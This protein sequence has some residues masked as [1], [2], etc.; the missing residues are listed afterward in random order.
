MDKQKIYSDFIKPI[1]I[2]TV[3]CVVTSALL[4][5]T[6][7]VTAPIILKA[8]IDSANAQRATL[9]PADSF[10]EIESTT[11]GVSQIYEADD[12]TGYVITSAAN[13]YNGSVPVM[14]AFDTNG[15]I[16]G[17]SFLPNSETPGFGQK[18]RE[19]DF[20]GQFAGMDAQPITLSDIDAVSGATVSSSAAVQ[21]I[22]YAIQGYAQVSGFGTE[23][24]VQDLTPDEVHEL[25]LPNS[26]ALTKVD[27]SADDI[28][29]VFKGENYG[30]IVYASEPG[31]NDKP[32]TAVVGFDG[33]GAIVGVWFNSSNETDGLG[34]QVTTNTEFTQGFIGDSEHANSDAIAGA[35]YS[36]N[37]ANIAVNK[38]V[39]FIMQEMG[40]Q[41][42]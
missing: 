35:T 22:N 11:E 4:A 31:Y 26:G 9:L 29:D 41:D 36:S 13:G 40:A 33:S 18:V 3:I 1:V 14:V 12:G 10:T 38:A 6:N 7:E 15:K 28:G 37:A 8:E 27:V 32:L 39:Q 19:E 34:T 2:L 25:V 21:A 17:V 20:Q 23:K 16:T 24:S 5:V 42:E 30:Y